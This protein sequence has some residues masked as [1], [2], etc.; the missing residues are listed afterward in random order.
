MYQIRLGGSKAKKRALVLFRTQRL[1]IITFSS[2]L[3]GVLAVDSSLEGLQVQ[4]RP[5]QDK[6]Q[7]FADRIGGDKFCLNVSD[8]FTR[9]NP[10]RLS[11]SWLAAF[12]SLLPFS[13]LRSADHLVTLWP[14]LPSAFLL[15]PMGEMLLVRFFWRDAPLSLDHSFLLLVWCIRLLRS[16]ADQ[17][18]RRPW[19]SNRGLPGLSEACDRRAFARGALHVPRRLR[20]SQPLL[21]W[22]RDQV[23]KVFRAARG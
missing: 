2:A 22:R 12:L 19:R 20:N 18:S 21:L 23:Q 8:A 14:L 5:S 9:P 7:G 4:L 16:P 3:Q 11:A 1:I 6:F 15:Q 13:A 17:R 10:L